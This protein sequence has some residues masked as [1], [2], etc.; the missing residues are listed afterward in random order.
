MANVYTHTQKV[1]NAFLLLL[2]NSLVMGKLVTTK[3]DKEWRNEEVAIGDTIKVRRPPEFVIREGATATPQDTKVGSVDLTINKQAG[4]D[5]EFTS[6]ELTLDVDQLLKNE[7]MRTKAAVVSQ[8]IDQALMNVTKEFPHWVGTPGEAIDSVPD[9]FAGPQRMDELAIP[10]NDR[11]SVLSPA[12]YWAL[13]GKLT[14]LNASDA[15]VR[16]AIERAKLP[17]VGNVQPYMSQ[18]VVNLITGTRLSSSGPQV[19]GASQ[20]VTYDSVRNTYKQTLNVKGL[21]ANATVKAGEV[22]TIAGVNAV[23]PRSKADLGYLQM[24]VVLADAEADGTGDAE[25]TIANPIITSAVPAYQTVTAA[26]ANSAP[27]TFMGDPSTSYRVNAAFARHSIAL[28]SAKLVTPKT[29]KFAFASDPETGI[30]VRYW[31]TSDGTNDTHLSRC[32]VLFGVAA[33]DRRL[34]V[35]MSGQAELDLGS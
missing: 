17:L 19:D 11:H 21:G 9:F 35:R 32:D 10:G 29:G 18:N 25:L 30:S 14:S 7:T 26:P 1:A 34:G 22:F 31:E 2:K 24:F 4:V 6:K 27:I 20:N 5:L 28:V 3:F 23:N 15:T 8:Y 12:D 13:A 33:L 16:T